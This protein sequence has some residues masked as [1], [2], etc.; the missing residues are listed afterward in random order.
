[1]KKR[2]KR[3]L[4]LVLLAFFLCALI[5]SLACKTRQNGGEENLVRVYVAHNE[6]QY[7]AAV[8]EFQERTGVAV[9]I[10]SAGTG[11]CLQR[12]ASEA[13]NPQCDVMW[14]GTVES[15]EA[16]VAYF[17]PY[18]CAEDAFIADAFKDP[19]DLWIGESQQP[20][21]IM[22]NRNLVANSDIPVVWK[23]LLDPKWKRQIA[24]ADPAS[25]GS[26]YTLLCNMILAV[27]KQADKSDGWA[28]VTALFDNAV[29]SGGS[30][31]VYQGVANGEYALGLTLEQLACPYVLENPE[32]VGMIYPAD[33]SSNVPDGVALVKGCPHEENAKRFIDFLLSADCQRFMSEEFDRRS[34]RGDIPQ[35]ASLPDLNS[36]YFI[37]YD[38]EWAG[39]GKEAVLRQWQTVQE[40]SGQ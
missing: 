39:V 6:K 36:I 31:T 19:N 5:G 27:S 3:L 21:V 4:R 24:S 25:S 34:V 10:V 12:I 9:E 28:F 17:Q 35:P 20:A 13:E 38:Y 11:D 30:S 40:Q 2:L 1:M 37:D 22:Y 26:A 33:G 18:V 16:Y 32:S 7:T 29:I 23:D 14:G 15:L 8:K